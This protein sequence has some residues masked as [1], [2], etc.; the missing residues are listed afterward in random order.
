M[1][2]QD[3]RLARHSLGSNLDLTVS[4]LA[5]VA[6]DG[7]LDPA[8]RDEAA[9]ILALVEPLVGDPDLGDEER[10]GRVSDVTGDLAR[11]DDAVNGPLPSE[12]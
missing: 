2:S 9:R 5:K 7:G 12:A 3:L 6:A 4:L 10:R 1:R 11:L 8:E